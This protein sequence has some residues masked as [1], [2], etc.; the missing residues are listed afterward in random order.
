MPKNA[1]ATG[2]KDR[3]S[4]FATRLWHIGRGGCIFDDVDRIP[5]A[6]ERQKLLKL[7]DA[8]IARCEKA[9]SA[10]IADR[11]KGGLGDNPQRWFVETIKLVRDLQRLYWQLHY[12]LEDNPHD[13][14]NAEELKE[15]HRLQQ[16]V[17]D[18][19]NLLD[20][21]LLLHQAAATLPVTHQD[22]GGQVA[23]AHEEL[24]S[25]KPLPGG[26]ESLRPCDQKAF[27]QYQYAVEKEPTIK[28]DDQAYNWLLREGKDDDIRLPQRKTWKRMLRRA[29]AF[30]G[31]S[32]NGSRI[33]NET[34]SVVSSKRI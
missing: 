32:K 9:I 12:F 17:F 10:G 8:S 31:Q 29:R 24:D 16:E 28:T 14:L 11:F 26:P 2:E 6:A 4:E 25:A 13:G 5:E 33:C 23:I 20:A 15:L 3:Q 34:R 30:Y 21:A 18:R 19:A 7:C 1:D 27:S 22:S